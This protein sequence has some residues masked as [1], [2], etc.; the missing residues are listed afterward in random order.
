MKIPPVALEWLEEKC[1]QHSWA[2][3]VA[4][5][6]VKREWVRHTGGRILRAGL[7]G[8]IMPSNELHLVIQD[9][10]IPQEYSAAVRNAALSV[11]LSQ[12]WRPV[13]NVRLTLF[14]FAVHPDESA[15]APFYAVAQEV[16]SHLLG[17]APECNH[18]IR[19]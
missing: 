19:W 2:S 7:S 10:G 18:N 1:S 6:T 17:V 15:Y 4:E 16:V 5:R 9:E 3:V 8:T 13:F 14:D 11:L 12:S